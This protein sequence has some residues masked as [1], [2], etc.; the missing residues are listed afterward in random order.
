MTKHNKVRTLF[1][2]LAIIVVGTACSLPR[3]VISEQT[4]ATDVP[5]AVTTAVPTTLPPQTSETIL[6]PE[7]AALEGS[8][9]A[10]YEMYSPGVVSLQYNSAEGSGQGTGFVIDKEGH[11][12][13]NY[14]VASDIDQLEVHFSSGLKVYGDVIGSD[15]DSDLAVIKV[16]VD[17]DELVPLPLGDSDQIKVGQMVVAIGNPYGLSGTMTVGVVSARGRVL[18]SMRQTSAGTY[19]SSGDTIQ[20]D[21]LINPG[22]SGGPLLNLNGEVIGVNRAIQTA[23]LSVSGDAI[24]T[25][26]GFAIS[27]NVVRKV[28]PSLIEKGSYEYPYLGMTSYSSMSLAMIEVLELPQSTGAYVSSVVKGGPADVAGIRG[29]MVQ[30]SVQGLYK[31][32]DLI[33]AVDGQ[34]IKDFSELMSYMVVNKNPGET[35]TFTVLRNGQTIDVDVLLGFRE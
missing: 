24:S 8:L 17:P 7:Y 14:H 13:T 27:S 18:D 35:I 3:M 22:N 19:Y 12:V 26:I 1:F 6:V 10:L 16:D 30:S 25:G 29:G 15:M 20:T 11:I 2:I 31:G 33:I 28:V 9:E 21:A 32:G 34:P 4:Q 23:G 5:S